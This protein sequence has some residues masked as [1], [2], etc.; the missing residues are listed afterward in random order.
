MGNSERKGSK[1]ETA[2]QLEQECR[3]IEYAAKTTGDGRWKDA[4]IETCCK[5]VRMEDLPVEV[6]PTGNRNA[7]FAARREFYWRVWSGR[8]K[9]IEKACI[10]IHAGQSVDDTMRV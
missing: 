4:L 6:L 3:I 10:L 9:M 1:G 7:Y 2:L 8:Q 5:G